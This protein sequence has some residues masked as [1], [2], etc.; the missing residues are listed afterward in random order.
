MERKLFYKTSPS[1]NSFFPKNHKGL[2]GVIT[3][4]I[5][6][7][8]VLAATVIVWGVVNNLIRKQ[9]ESS[10]ACFG[11]YDKVT[12][13]GIYTCYD[14]IDDT[15]QFSLNIGDIEVDKVIVSV[16]SEGSTNSY[17]LTN[18]AQPI[19][20]LANYSSTGFGTDF[21]KLPGKNA[22]RTYI[23]SGFTEKPDLIKIAPIIGG[24]QCEVS[25]TISNIEVCF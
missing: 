20:G 10:E 15:F 3:A 6:I 13:N 21:I 25:D 4:I 18:D 23:A 12:I 8:L 5:L 7:A 22:G 17:T 24:Q 19:P 11:N 14:S 2:S 16:S 1:E 9:M